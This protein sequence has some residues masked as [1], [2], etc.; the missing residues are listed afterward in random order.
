VEISVP[1]I[2]SHASQE[3]RG[4]CRTP[5]Q[6]LLENPHADALQVPTQVLLLECPDQPQPGVLR[7]R[8]R[9]H[10]EDVLGDV[11]EA[12]FLEPR[13]VLGGRFQRGAEGA[14]GFA[15]ERVVLAELAVRGEGVVIAVQSAL[16][17]L[18]F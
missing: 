13:T 1:D 3:H 15:Q 18:K 7:P 17:A 10:L 6:T 2:L 8:A 4:L 14:G 9:G 5:P 12:G 16:D 11:L